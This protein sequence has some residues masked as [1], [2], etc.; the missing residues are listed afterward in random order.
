MK[1]RILLGVLMM[2]AGD[3]V[4]GSVPTGATPQEALPDG[5]PAVTTE[6]AGVINPDEAMAL[7]DTTEG[8]RGPSNTTRNNGDPTKPITTPVPVVEQPEGEGKPTIGN[9]TNAL[10]DHAYHTLSPQHEVTLH[11]SR[12]IKKS[13]DVKPAFV[14]ALGTDNVEPGP[15]NSAFRSIVFKY[16]EAHGQRACVAY[17]DGTLKFLA[18]GTS[19]SDW[20]AMS[21]EE[22]VACAA[23]VYF[24]QSPSADNPYVS[25]RW[26]KKDELPEVTTAGDD[27]L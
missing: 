21:R 19:Y 12:E 9:S 4:G 3:A 23:I 20:Y 6:P 27:S 16:P 1:N 7:P 17:K 22:N 11:I 18:S 8:N 14:E 10:T 13:Y 15:F 2:T 26:Y 25:V 5:V 24:N